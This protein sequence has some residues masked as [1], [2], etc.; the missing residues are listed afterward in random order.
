M[1]NI[2]YSYSFLQLNKKNRRSAF[3][4]AILQVSKSLCYQNALVKFLY[5]YFCATIMAVQKI[6]IKFLLKLA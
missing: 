5:E 6:L 1:D 4:A 3:Y 2:I